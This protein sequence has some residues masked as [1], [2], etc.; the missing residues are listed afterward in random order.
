MDGV[1][2][3]NKVPCLFSGLAPAERVLNSQPG[4]LMDDLWGKAVSNYKM[5]L[6][7]TGLCPMNLVLFVQIDWDFHICDAWCAIPTRQMDGLMVAL[8]CWTMAYSLPESLPLCPSSGSQWSLHYWLICLVRPQVTL[9]QMT[10]MHK[11]GH[12]V[13]D[14]SQLDAIGLDAWYRFL[15][16]SEDFFILKITPANCYLY[17]KYPCGV[18]VSTSSSSLDLRRLTSFCPC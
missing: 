11:L 13:S 8:A 16:F 5:Y 7:A 12:L 2:P 6:I 9:T 3:F 17:Y 15:P 4:P 14:R 10:L 1:L 18:H